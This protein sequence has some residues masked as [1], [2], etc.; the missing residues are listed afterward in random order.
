MVTGELE[1]GEH[2]SGHLVTFTKAVGR[3]L[4]KD[5][6]ADVL[7]I[8]GP[9]GIGCPVIASISGADFV[10]AVTE[11]TPIAK[12]GLVRLLEVTRHFNVPAGV[13]INKFDLSKE[14]FLEFKEFINKKLKLKILGEIPVDYEILKS[15]MNAKPILEYNPSSRASVAIGRICEEVVKFIDDP[16]SE[17]DESSS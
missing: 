9:P 2:N 10:L 17:K 7:L 4:A 6:R 13:V 1:V 15:L 16:Y 5:L 3:R 14:Y 12:N 8:D 11:P